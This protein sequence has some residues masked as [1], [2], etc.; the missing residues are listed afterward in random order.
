[1][2]KSCAW[3]SWKVPFGSRLGGLCTICPWYDCSSGCRSGR[4][5][6]RGAHV[7]SDFFWRW[8][9][10]AKSQDTFRYI[11]KSLQRFHT[12]WGLL[13]LVRRLPSGEPCFSSLSICVHGRLSIRDV[14]C[15]HPGQKTS[16]TC[17]KRIVDERGML[18]IPR[19]PYVWNPNT[20]T[21]THLLWSS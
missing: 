19:G 13:H 6:C 21:N 16:F 14:Q 15:R 8:M 17:R 5:H 4:Q 20:L 3:F 7:F 9:T 10:Q 2:S 1:M 18:V 12:F 11:L